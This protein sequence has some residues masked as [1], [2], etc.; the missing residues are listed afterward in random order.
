[1]A[2]HTLS[3]HFSTFFGRI[4]P[5]PGFQQTAAREH[6]AIT[7]LI[8]SRA[9]PAGVLEPYCFLQGSY[10]QETA[11]YSINDVDIVAL[12]KA[13]FPGERVPG[14]VEWTRDALFSTVA[15]A[16]AADTR[17]QGR[18]RYAP[19][20]MV[21]HVDLDI[22][23]EVLPVVYRDGIHDS[24]VEPFVL[25]RPEHQRWE[26]GYAREHQRLLTLKNALMNT[27]GNFKPMVK[28][29]KHLRS[30]H[31]IDAVSFHLECLL[32]AVPSLAF[33]GTPA[34]YITNVLTAIVSTPAST[35][36]Q[37]GLMTPCGDREI[38]AAEEWDY[39]SWKQFH[40]AAHNWL[41]LA[42]AGGM[43]ESK[44][45]AIQGWRLLLGENYFPESVT[46]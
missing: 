5:S 36:Y 33:I 41:L 18:V 22:R 7:T 34:D 20:S 45:A 44:A 9:G 40:S 35:W 30:R 26:L 24:A 21:I 42:S 4:N 12:C 10:R 19:T 1:M 8:A 25:F 27:N 13:W 39:T 29:L 37:Q 15:S 23:V 31:Q 6:D 16:I 28:V 43:A 11:I 38:F 3:G 32:Y 14:A 17:Y 2:V 46:R